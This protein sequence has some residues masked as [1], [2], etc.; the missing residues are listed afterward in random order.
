MVLPDLSVLALVYHTFQDKFDPHFHPNKYNETLLVPLVLALEVTKIYYENWSKGQPKWLIANIIE[1]DEE[2]KPSYITAYEENSPAIIYNFKQEDMSKIGIISDNLVWNPTLVPI[3]VSDLIGKTLFHIERS[4]D[5][6]DEVLT[7]YGHGFAYKMFSSENNHGNDV[8]VIIDD[9]IGDLDD[10]INSP[11]LVAELV[12]SQHD[13]P[14]PLLPPKKDNRGSWV[15]S[16]YKFATAKGYVDIKWWGT[17]NGY[18][19]ERVCFMRIL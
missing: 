14:N 8:E 2:G 1:L 10:L 3:T 12:T 17:S 5:H 16:F 9:I 13:D 15:W 18:Y 4:K 6:K 7:F 19:S 11:I